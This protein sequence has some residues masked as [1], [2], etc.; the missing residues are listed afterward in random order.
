MYTSLSLFAPLPTPDEMKAWDDIATHDYNIAPQ[1]LMENASREALR[2]LQQEVPITAKTQTL[3]LMG[4]GNNGGDG[5]ALARHLFNLGSKVLVCHK[6]SVNRMSKATQEQVEIAQ[7][8]G[9][10]F[11]PLSGSGTLVLP[12]EW[13]HPDII[14]DAMCGTGFKGPLTEQTQEIVKDLNMRRK[15]SFIFSLDIPTGLCGYTGVPLP[16]AVK[17]HATVTFE[18]GKPGLYFP[19]ALEYTGKLIVAPIGIPAGTKALK[20][21]TWQLLAPSNHSLPR[22]SRFMHKGNGGKVLIIGGSGTMHGAPVLAAL[23]ALRAGAGIVHLACP[24][25]QAP[26]CRTQFPEIIVHGIG[27]AAE[28]Q[29]N[30]PAEIEQ[31]IATLAPSAIVIGPGMGREPVVKEILEAI[32]QIPRRAPVLIDA[33]ALYFIG[34]PDNEFE[35]SEHK[36]PLRLIQPQD[37]LTPHPGE[38]AYLLPHSFFAEKPMKRIK[39]QLDISAA[40]FVQTNRSDALQ[41]FTAKSPATLLLK[42]FGTI[43]GKAGMPNTLCPIAASSLAVAGSGDVLS[44]IIG[45]FIASGIS[46]FEATCLGAYV[47][48][49]AGEALDAITPRGHLASEI[50]AKVPFILNELYDRL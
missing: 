25:L 50:A 12:L 13:R 18:A 19:E 35:Q 4:N 30:S 39:M 46:S 36:I 7:S 5:A 45:A 22:P 23:G 6:A 1:V 33:D 9:V 29:A 10:N 20:P 41:T 17:A 42:G 2:V 28:W 47:H 15:H 43:I 31:L 24:F 37:V 32:L 49:K 3:I 38:M 44:G 34:L 14:V 8:L 26:N 48:A 21:N 40:Q 27:S 11:L 16:E